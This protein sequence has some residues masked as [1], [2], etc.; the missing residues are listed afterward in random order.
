MT[1][2]DSLRSFFGLSVETRAAVI[3]APT[4][5]Q[6]PPRPG[7]S[8]GLVAAK[9]RAD[10][11]LGLMRK[12]PNLFAAV[13]QR[14]MSI[15]TFPAMILNNGKAVQSTGAFSWARDFFAL[16]AA[17]SPLDTNDIFPR[18][19]G[20]GLMAQIV[21]DLLLVGDAFI[22]PTLSP[23]GRPV[24]LTRLHPRCVWLVRRA[25]GDRYEYR[26]TSGGAVEVY[27]AGQVAHLRLLSASSGGAEE[28]GVGAGEPLEGI[29][30]AAA[31]AV[32]KAGVMIQSGGVD[33]L[34]RPNSPA[35]AAMLMDEATRNIIVENAKT[36]LGG[37]LNGDRRIM[38]LGGDFTLEPTGFEPA[39]LQATELMGAAQSAELSAVGVTPIMVGG[40]STNFATAAMQLRVQY[41]LDASLVEVLSASLL[42][43][44][45]RAFARSASRSTDPMA[46]TATLDLATHPG[47]MAMRTEAIGRMGQLI[48]MGWT[49]EQAAKAEGI[50]LPRPDGSPAQSPVP[51]KPPAST[52][53]TV[54]GEGAASRSAPLQWLRAEPVDPPAPV[55]RE[56]D[57]FPQ[58]MIRAFRVGL[59]WQDEGKA[60]D[61][62]KPETVRRASWAVETGGPPS[63][64]WVVEA[65]A[66]HRRHHPDGVRP[67]DGRKA[68]PTPLDVATALWGI[69]DA[70][71]AAWWD[72]QR[73]ALG[74]DRVAAAEEAI[75]A[76]ESASTAAR[77]ASWAEIDRSRAPRQERIRLSA[78]Q[79]Q[80]DELAAYQ[81][82]I[83][84]ALPS[85][86]T[87][88]RS[89]GGTRARLVSYGAIDWAEVLGSSVDARARWSD[90]LAPQWLASWE[91]AAA[92]AL[93]GYDLRV[94]MPTATQDTLNELEAGAAA[95]A[96]YSR[97][98]VRLHV[99]AGIRDG[100]SVVDIA[101]SL[102]QDQAFAPF[103]ALRIA[104]TETIRSDSAG[105]Q[106][107]AA[108]AERV[109]V[110]VEQE[111]MSDPM[112]ALWDRRHDRLD[113]ARRPIGGQW[114][115]PL[116][117]DTRG[118]GLSGDPGEDC[119]CVCATAL[120]VVQVK[121][122]A[123]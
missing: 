6:I 84:A 23:A 45:A 102:R 107:R 63:D 4:V 74:A 78:R 96:D 60:G 111:W 13:N 35:G 47:A 119:N 37:G 56:V 67:I 48:G 14:A 79:I 57:R 8:V 98:R 97:E 122:P 17:P 73:E 10:T 52:E 27:P 101:E 104:R 99:E 103:R 53:P 89:G 82:R 21:A 12:S 106:A 41:E 120:R 69:L 54:V 109:G 88:E 118:P 49:P 26:P 83:R 58:S 55:A 108:E 95:V 1:L 59:R 9:P 3:P 30:S 115:T 71:D 50:D 33:I 38:A 123:V 94:P 62:L 36:A 70:G 25:D 7:I 2:L 77:S 75:R 121:P 116:G 65:S 44:L 87:G 29:V 105:V 66:W 11:H 86:V 76:T 85:A 68:D 93:P 91:E 31:A 40:Q 61:G 64:A 19:T 112:A 117:V 5:K 18:Q 43:P 51:M 20:I 114:R 81:R 28:M 22:V 110:D 80:A 72:R 39:D 16:L 32:D 90:G 113:G 24:A 34:I 92:G 42:T 15:A 46:I 100:L